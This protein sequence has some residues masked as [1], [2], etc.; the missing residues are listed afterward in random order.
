MDEIRTQIKVKISENNLLR[1]RLKNMTDELKRI[2]QM[3]A[4]SKDKPDVMQHLMGQ[5]WQ[6]KVD[7][8]KF[9]EQIDDNSDELED[10][11]KSLLV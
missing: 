10:L 8:S 6:L 7:K 3:M 9:E 11:G 5:Y 2:E 4:R 1:E